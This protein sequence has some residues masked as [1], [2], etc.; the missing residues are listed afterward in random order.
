MKV[1]VVNSAGGCNY[2]TDLCVYGNYAKDNICY[3]LAGF[4]VLLSVSGILVD[5]SITIMQMTA[6]VEVM[7]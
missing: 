7:Q 3:I 4:Q 6:S 5:L 2:A 1:S